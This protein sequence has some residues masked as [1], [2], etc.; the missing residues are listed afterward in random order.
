M[1]HSLAYRV[2]QAPFAERKFEPVLR[3]NHLDCVKGVLDIGCGPGTNAHHF[4]RI[5]YRGLDVNPAYIET[6]R[7]RHRRDFE[8][9][10]VRAYTLPAGEGRDFALINS[11]LH[12]IGDVAVRA[13]LRQ[14]AALL[15]TDG[16]VHALELVMPPKRSPARLMARMDR[17]DHPR[18]LSHWE[19]LFG[20]YFEPVVFEPYALGRFGIELWSMV[21]FKGRPRP[22]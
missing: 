5:P 21:Y 16:H 15:T 18:S 3:H 7:R 4:A 12:H 2:W 9:A 22:V 11:F 19:A 20:E 8:V 13:V 10:D 6:A 14:V 1:E 17:G